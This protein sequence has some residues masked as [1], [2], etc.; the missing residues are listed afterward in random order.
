MC[1]SQHALYSIELRGEYFENKSYLRCLNLRERLLRVQSSLVWRLG[2][3]LSKFFLVLRL[4]PCRR[5]ALMLRVLALIFNISLKEP[6]LAML[7]LA[8]RSDSILG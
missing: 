6:K 5:V 7:T 4:P 8:L 3:V 2:R 1:S